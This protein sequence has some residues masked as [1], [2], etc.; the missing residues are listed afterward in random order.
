MPEVARYKWNS[1]GAIEDLPREQALL[2][3][4]REQA[5]QRGLDA[6]AVTQ[7]FAAQIEASKVVQRELFAA[8][9]GAGQGKFAQVVD[10][11]TQIRP[12][13]DQLSPSLLDALAAVRLPVAASALPPLSFTDSSPAAAGVSLAPL[14]R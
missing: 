13:L 14:V 12:R 4:V 5:V 7:F 9:Q 2:Q 11:A 6:D 1:G 8:W 3:S 10:L